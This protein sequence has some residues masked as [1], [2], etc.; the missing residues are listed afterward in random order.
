MSR[1]AII[2]EEKCKPSKCKQECKRFCP[3][4]MVGKECVVVE[5]TSKVSSISESLCIGCGVCAGSSSKA[6]PFSAIQIINVPVSLSKDVVHRYGKNTFKLHRLPVPKKGKVLGII[7]RN[8]TGKSSSLMIISGKM[9]PNFGRFDN[10]PEWEEIIKTY[11]GSDL[12]SV[13][14]LIKA[15][16]FK[17][18][19][20]P[21]FVDKIPLEYKSSTV[22]ELFE[23]K[24]E[25]KVKEEIIKSLE[26]ENVLDRKL[27]ELSGGEV[28][29][30]YIG[31]VAITKAD[32]YIFDEP[33]SFLDIKQRMMVSNVIRSLCDINNYVVV[34]EHDLSL[35]DYLSDY[36]C[37]IYGKAGKYGVVTVPFSV[38]EGINHYLNGFIPTENMRFRKDKLDFKLAETVRDELDEKGIETVYPELT[39]TLGSFSLKVEQGTFSTSEIVVLL[40]QNGG[41]KTTFLKLM[42]GLL[43][44]D[45]SNEVPQLTVS[46]KPQM[47]SPKSEK[48]VQEFLYEKFP[49]IFSDQ[50]FMHDV[51]KP[52]MIEELYGQV[53]KTLSG[54]QSQCLGICLALAKPADVYFI[55][56]PSAYLDCEQRIVV[57]KL[58][59]RFILNSKKTAF[60][61]E[62]DF[63]MATYMADKIILYRGE[64]GVSTVALS[65]QALLSGMNLFL[66]DMNITLRREP[67][68]HRPRINKVNSSKDK[69]QKA[70]GTYFFLDTADEVVVETTNMGKIEE[71]F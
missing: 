44:S 58:L 2:D 20:K 14:T 69:E 16:N 19:Y 32:M 6:C 42:V 22:R 30:T 8:G 29:R 61:V 34:V 70:N 37:C 35:L 53:V 55:D 18:S 56:E 46:Y 25:R 9:K 4:N 64:P 31:L 12:Q 48:T 54:G 3:V 60:I 23:R 62:H 21:Q 10:P 47:I 71:L 36:I 52:L 59:K 57:A 38:R 28:Q 67:T 43:K 13:F 26:L 7:G 27:E 63:L 51:M 15:G 5:K 40:G 33:S 49:H 45:N 17:A 24:D 41:G 11:R 68:T 39:K 66:K 50:L 65:P 1:I